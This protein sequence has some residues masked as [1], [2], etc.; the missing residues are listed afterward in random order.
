[1]DIRILRYP[2]PLTAK[3]PGQACLSWWCSRLCD[4]PLLLSPAVMKVP[5]P[6]VEK[7]T[8]AA[9]GAAASRAAPARP[10]MSLLA[11]PTWTP[12]AVPSRHYCTKYL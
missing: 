6:R 8:P 10:V 3:R 1:M 7:S 5:I 2:D 4:H 12:A 11:I 9:R